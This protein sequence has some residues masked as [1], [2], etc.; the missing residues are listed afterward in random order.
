MSKRIYLSPPH[1]GTCELEFVKEVFASNFI[2]PVGPMLVDFEKKAAEC[3]QIPHTLAVASG[4]AALHLILRHIGIQ[5]GDIVL[6]STLTFIGG[7]SPVIF[8]GGELVFIDADPATWTMDPVRLEE[9]IVGCERRGKVIKTVIATDLYGQCADVDRLKVICDSRNIPLVIDAAESLGATYKGCPAG[10]GAYASI[11]SFNGNKIITTSGGGL[12]ASSDQ[13]LIDHARKLSTQAR[14]DFPYYQHT[15]IG[16]NYRMSNV[17]AGIGLGQLQVLA[18]RVKRK[19]VINSMYRDLLGTVPGLSF[20]PQ[21]EYGVSNCWL[22]VIQLDPQLT[23]VS[24]EDIRLA[25]EKQNIETRPVWKPMHMQPV[26]SS[27][28]A[29]GGKVAEKIFRNGLC[30]PSGTSMLDRDINKVAG[31]ITNEIQNRTSH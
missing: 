8:E 12:V 1:M 14:D 20:M 26:F 30:L 28:D 16:F 2:A 31:S 15:E 4:T 24:P 21:T 17:L 3:L 23:A 5:P 11:Y 18:E 29:I 10:H 13:S 6:A 7:V 22:T 9:A 19:Q 27:A 25:L